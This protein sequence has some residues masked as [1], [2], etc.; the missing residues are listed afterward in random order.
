MACIK[1]AFGECTTLLCGYRACAYR[2]F[3]YARTSHV[4]ALPLLKFYWHLACA[5]PSEFFQENKMNPPSF[6]GTW[7]RGPSL[8]WPGFHWHNFEVS[9]SN[10]LVLIVTICMARLGRMHVYCPGPDKTGTKFPGQL[11]IS[12]WEATVGISL[13]CQLSCTH[14]YRV[15]YVSVN[16]NCTHRIAA[17]SDCCVKVFTQRDVDNGHRPME[18]LLY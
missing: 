4:H 11:C 16:W 18:T 12:R 2:A 1:S 6:I 14:V 10:Y 8:I 5:R 15:V 13:P 17:W 9:V 7:R 3:M